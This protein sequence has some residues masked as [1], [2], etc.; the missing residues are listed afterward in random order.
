VTVVAEIRAGERAAGREP[1]SV[2]TLCRFFCIQGDAKQ[3]RQVAN[4]MFVAHATVPVYESFFRWLGYGEAID[5]LVD[6]WRGGDRGRALELAPPE[7]VEDVFVLGEPDEQRA[8]LEDFRRRGIDSPVLRI[9]PPGGARA[10]IDPD[11]YVEA[12][13]AL[14]PG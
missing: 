4:R 12:I 7:L 8:R 3:A 2:E 13:Q 1:G 11:V 5:P 9:V 10:E 14:A 6:A